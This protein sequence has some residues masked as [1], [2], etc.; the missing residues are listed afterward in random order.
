LTVLGTT[1]FPPGS[2]ALDAHVMSLPLVRLLHARR[3]FAY[4]DGR[5]AVVYT[6]DRRTRW[7][8]AEAAIVDGV[9]RP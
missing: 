8:M 2:Q 1:P 3:A 9:L 7:V 4:G 6:Y 5:R